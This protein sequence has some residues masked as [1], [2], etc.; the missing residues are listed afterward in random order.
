MQASVPSR[1][2]AAYLLKQLPPWYL[3]AP[4]SCHHE[5]TNAVVPFLQVNVNCLAAAE[6][7]RLFGAAMVRAAFQE[8]FYDESGGAAGRAGLWAHSEHQLSHSLH[9]DTEGRA[10]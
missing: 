5:E 1:A 4:V 2:T 8:W 10:L 3:L 6:L 9:P 7:S